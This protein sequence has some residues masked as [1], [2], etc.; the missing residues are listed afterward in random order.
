MIYVVLGA[1]IAGI[2]NIFMSLQNTLYGKKSFTILKIKIIFY[3]FNILGVFFVPASKAILY[4]FSKSKIKLNSHKIIYNSYDFDLIS[5]QSTKYKQSNVRK[6]IKNIVMIARLDNIKDQETLLKAFANLKESSWRLK[7]VGNGPNMKS[8]KRISR[9][10]S[11]NE[12]EIFYGSSNNIPNILAES[13]IFAFSTTEA[14][15][16]GKV[17]IEAMAAKVPIIAS[18]VSACR[19]ILF[20]GKIGILVP[21]KNINEW[22]INLKKLIKDKKKRTIIAEDAFLYKDFFNSKNIANKWHLLLKNNFKY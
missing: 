10:L 19:E 13:D 14:E 9:K 8:L 18:D 20:N 11:L 16:F 21:P 2:K 6:K 4:S 7:F 17:L 12:E 3:I 1:K 22:T 5:F 15:G